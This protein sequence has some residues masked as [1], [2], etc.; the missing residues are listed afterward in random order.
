MWIRVSPSCK[1]APEDSRFFTFA[2]LLFPKRA[3]MLKVRQF[4]IE[5]ILQQTL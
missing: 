1:Q 2:G 3:S 4:N 5:Q